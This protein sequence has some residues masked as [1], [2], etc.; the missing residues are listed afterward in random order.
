LHSTT[1]TRFD[2]SI[3]LLIKPIFQLT[4]FATLP[5][6]QNEI[7]HVKHAANLNIIVPIKLSANQRWKL[8][9]LAGGLK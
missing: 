7:K 5:K 9:R 4:C 1:A 3:R 6:P 2:F 8:A